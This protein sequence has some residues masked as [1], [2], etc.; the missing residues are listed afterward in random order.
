MA[1]P[2][3]PKLAYEL[4]SERYAAGDRTAFD[5]LPRPSHCDPRILH[6]PTLD[7]CDF[8]KE[9]TELQE[10]R[11]RLGIS[12][13]GHSNRKWPCPADQ[14]RSKS[15]YHA[16]GGNRPANRTKMDEEW[17]KLKEELAKS[18]YFDPDDDDKPKRA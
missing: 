4:A 18:G 2:D 1:D 12:N 17:K 16:W 15:Q 14:A 11:E 13:T 9:N 10:E 5:G 7:D 8:C 3:Q 6:H